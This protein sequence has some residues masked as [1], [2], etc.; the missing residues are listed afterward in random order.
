[1]Y[2]PGTVRAFHVWIWKRGEKDGWRGGVLT[3]PAASPPSSSGRSPAPHY[4]SCPRKLHPCEG[5][6]QAL[7]PTKRFPF[8]R[9]PASGLT[10]GSWLQPGVSRS[11]L[12]SIRGLEGEVRWLSATASPS[13][14]AW[15]APT[16]P[17]DPHT[18]GTPES[19]QALPLP[20]APNWSAGSP[21]S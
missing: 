17:H 8:I 15:P 3:Y 12:W 16:G 20:R 19:T 7:Q 13:F 9:A 18:H 21:R 11:G 5:C 6:L 1:M 10:L 4:P 14:S 2:G